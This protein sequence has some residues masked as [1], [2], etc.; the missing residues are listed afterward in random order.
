MT[1]APLPICWTPLT[2]ALRSVMYLPL[3]AARAVLSVFTLTICLMAT[4]CDPAPEG[5]T[6]SA[7]PV[8]ATAPAAAATVSEPPPASAAPSVNPVVS[9]SDLA[10]IYGRAEGVLAEAKTPAV[11]SQFRPLQ[12]VQL[13]P[14]GNML[15]VTASGND[16]QILLPAFI[17]GQRF[18]IEATVDSPADTTMQIFYLRK[19]QTSYTDGQAQMAPLVKGRNVV[20][21][22]FPAADIVDPLRVDIG[23]A[24]GDYTI[25]SM[26]AK[27]L[28]AQ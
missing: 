21:F 9:Q 22:Q 10:D 6:T 7:S 26:I 18:I 14:V 3:V 16:P 27:V 15:K 11:F 19:G 25:E 17:Q 28:P 13:T 20:Y 8:N 12:Q 23:T 4:A 5:S 2:R 24:A 1:R